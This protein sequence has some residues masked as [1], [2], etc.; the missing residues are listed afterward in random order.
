VLAQSKS[1]TL[2]SQVPAALPAD[3]RRT[4]VGA[5]RDASDSAFHLS[6]WLSAALVFGAGLISLAGV[7]DPRRPVAAHDCPGG[8]ICGAPEDAG[9]RPAHAAALALLHR[10]AA[11][12]ARGP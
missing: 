10:P 1:R 12:H 2:T 11:G 3:Q 6:I 7:R 9:R 5:L 4:L 8:A